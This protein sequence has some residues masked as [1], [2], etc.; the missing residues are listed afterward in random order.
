M[1]KEM[2]LVAVKTYGK[3]EY[4]LKEEAKCSP[5]LL[6]ALLKR[7]HAKPILCI[8]LALPLPAGFA[9]AQ[10]FSVPMQRLPFLSMAADAVPLDA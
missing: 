2:E 8:L 4:P 10:R 5:D 6:K 1:D 3:P 7:W 9:P